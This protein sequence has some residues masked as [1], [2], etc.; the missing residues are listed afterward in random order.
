MSL[1]TYASSVFAARTRVGI[2]GQPS[3]LTADRE[4]PMTRNEL[5]AVISGRS[6]DHALQQPEL[7]DAFGQ[8]EKSDQTAARVPRAGADRAEQQRTNTR[9]HAK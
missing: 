8:L 1:R 6:P 9:R 2:S 4:S 7:L 5:E 3:C